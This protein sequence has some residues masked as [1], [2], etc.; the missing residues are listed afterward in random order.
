MLESVGGAED[1]PLI[2][3]AYTYLGQFLDH[4]I[5]FD[6]TSI[7]EARIDPEALTNYRSPSFDLDS[8]YGAGPTTQPYLYQRED[9]DLFE[10]GCAK[11]FRIDF[12]LA[13]TLADSETQNAMVPDIGIR[14]DLPRSWNR[15]ALIADPR[16]DENLIVAQLHL[17]FLLFHNSIV[18]WLRDDRSR[19]VAP[20]S[21]S[22]F[23]E[24]RTLAIRH[25]QWML[26]HDF[27]PLIVGDDMVKSVLQQGS[28]MARTKRLF[29]P[30]EFS[31]AAYRFGHSMV[32]PQYNISSSLVSATLTD[33][34]NFSGRG[35]SAADV[36]I[37][38]AWVVEWNRLLHFD[39]TLSD[40]L[41]RRI[42]PYLTDDLAQ[43]SLPGGK[44]HS[45]PATNLTRGNR[46]GL[47]SGQRL[48][49]LFGYDALTP[50]QIGEG[51]DGRVATRHKFD[52]ETPLWFYILKEALVCEEGKRL[53]PVGGRI[54]AEVFIGLLELDENSILNRAKWWTPTL[55][56]KRKEDFSFEDLLRFAGVLAETGKGP[57]LSEPCQYEV[58]NMCFS[59]VT[60]R[61]V[62]D[63]AARSNGQR[64]TVLHHRP[65]AKKKAN[66]AKPARRR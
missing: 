25:Y 10:I 49:E 8:V 39:P 7:E 11:K 40:T 27:L 57:A 58:Q 46:L 61:G 14:A 52:R 21:K 24:A 64:R 54:V 43:I 23:I 51:P 34:F 18:Q 60:K 48:A 35:G 36:P 3:A 65:M 47:P 22:V 29:M 63:A 33:L 50:K 6:P 28:V 45:L 13:A 26:L 55:P 2:P 17:A 56:S 42:D 44:T 37:Q 38:E 32:R 31:A 19:C 53:G 41:S 1:N 9:R 4:D 20:L 30:V 66:P 15:F 62:E 16:N 12:Q 59:P 5:T